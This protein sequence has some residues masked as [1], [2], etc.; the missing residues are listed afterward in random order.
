METLGVVIEIR[1]RGD[2]AWKFLSNKGAEIITNTILGVPY[3]K[4][5]I[6]GPKTPF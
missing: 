6:M 2:L 3:Y 4:Y 1:G 5:N